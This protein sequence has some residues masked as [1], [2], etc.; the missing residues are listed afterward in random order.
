MIQG[1]EKAQIQNLFTGIA[2]GYDLAND[3]ITFG[4]ARGW[5]K[6]LVTWSGAKPGDKVLDCAT[7][8]GDLAFDFKKKVGD[9]G[10]VLATDFCQGMLDQAPEKA[11]T[12]DLDVTFEWADVTQL[13]YE[14]HQFDCTSIAY[15][16]RNV[17]DPVKALKEMARVTKPGG[18]V[19]IL[20]TGRSQWA[21]MQWGFDFYFKNVVP[22]LGGAVTGD[23][24]AY[25]Y[26]NKSSK[27]FPCREEFLALM[28]Q[29]Q[30]FSKCEYKSLL[31]GASFL[32]KGIVQ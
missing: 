11:R 1:P 9:A 18:V 3:L 26:L 5:R 22:I 20:E 4:M 24:S 30:S 25:K 10:Q 8:T 31:G 6:K 21:L 23:S 16:I 12:L 13:K 29:A 14:D 7:G 28:K 2:P 27:N 32:Y 19:M 15:G 17:E